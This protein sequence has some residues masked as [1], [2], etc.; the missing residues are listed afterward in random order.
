MKYDIT[1]SATGTYEIHEVDE[2]KS[3]EDAK[4]YAKQLCESLRNF[5]ESSGFTVDVATYATIKPI[6]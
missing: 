5:T 2:F 1:A 3:E 6:K 4:K